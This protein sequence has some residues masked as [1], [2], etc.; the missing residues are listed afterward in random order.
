MPWP[1]Q[2][3]GNVTPYVDNFVYEHCVNVLLRREKLPTLEM[4]VGGLGTVTLTRQTHF[5]KIESGVQ[6]L[7]YHVQMIF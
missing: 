6:Q 3:T 1:I 7:S 4:V 5:L 2:I